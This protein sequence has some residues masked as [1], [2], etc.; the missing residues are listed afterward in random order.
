M[1]DL[2]L[3]YGKDKFV[4]AFD[5]EKKTVTNS[6]IDKIIKRLCFETILS[7]YETVCPCTGAICMYM[8]I[9]FKPLF[10]TS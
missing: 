3:F 9:I 5:L 4:C 10:L 6:V 1:V 8:T 2:D 7:P